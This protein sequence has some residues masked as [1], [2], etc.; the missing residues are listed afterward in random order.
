MAEGGGPQPALKFFRGRR[1]VGALQ[2]D[3]DAET[4]PGLI[5]VENVTAKIAIVIRS[6]LATLAE[7]ESVYALRDLYDL[8]EIAA[9]DAYNRRVADKF[10]EAKAKQERGA[11]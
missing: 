10:Y 4:I 1:S 8:L 2:Q 11:R 5:A 9:V 6:K 3:Y 7:L